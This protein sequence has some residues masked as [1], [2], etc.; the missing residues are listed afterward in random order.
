MSSETKKKTKPK[1]PKKKVSRRFKI[2]ENGLNDREQIFID[3]YI[4]NGGKGREAA[5]KAGYAEGSAYQRSYI[6]MARPAV[7][8][9]YKKQINK[10]MQIDELMAGLTSMARGE[11]TEECVVMIRDSLGNTTPKI[12]EKRVAPKDRN[13]AY[14]QIA[15]FHS[16]LKENVEIRADE[17]TSAIHVAILEGFKGRN[18]TIDKQTSVEEKKA[19]TSVKKDE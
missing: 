13:N 8:K 9:Y 7:E 1:A 6:I 10:T 5:L 4:L 11:E 15:K 2:N 17:K 3:E 12:I 19:P 16:V 18:I 14:F